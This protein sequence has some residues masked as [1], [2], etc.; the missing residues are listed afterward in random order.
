MLE[1][2]RQAPPVRVAQHP[3]AVV[4]V[5][6]QLHVADGDEAVEP[7]V[8]HGLHD[9]LEAL[10][11]DPLFQLAGACAATVTGKGLAADQRHVAL[12]DDRLDVF[13]RS[14]QSPLAPSPPQ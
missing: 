6:V 3:V 14:V 5:A 10:L 12:L 1:D 11:L 2:L 8:G 13:G 7:G 4:Q 9:L